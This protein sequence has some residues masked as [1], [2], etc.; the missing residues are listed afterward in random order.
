MKFNIFNT[1]ECIY[2]KII[3]LLIVL[4]SVLSIVWYFNSADIKK[5]DTAYII[6]ILY[7]LFLFL[8]GVYNNYMQDKIEEKFFERKNYYL[9][10]LNLKDLFNTIDFEN[11]S[12]KDI[13]S[14]IIAFK[15]FTGRTNSLK[16]THPYISEQGFRFNNKE[17]ILED[18]FISMRKMLIEKLNIEISKYIDENS[19]DIKCPYPNINDL[20]FNVEEW[21]TE[22][23]YLIGNELKNMQDY[24]YK[25][26]SDF[27]KEQDNLEIATQKILNKYKCYKLHIN[28]NIKKIECTYGQKIKFEFLQQEQFVYEIRHIRQMLEDIQSNM[29]HNTYLSDTIIEVKYDIQS[30][31]NKIVSLENILNEEILSNL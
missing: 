13:Y 3:Y 11:C 25:L 4:V 10:L 28:W 8:I 16:N 19:I 29:C 14:F 26:F 15:T 20:C 30:I 5:S 9:N 22:Y 1:W 24:I 12:D 17:L 18:D 6:S 21:C 27:Q 7:A 2:K 31:H 23:T